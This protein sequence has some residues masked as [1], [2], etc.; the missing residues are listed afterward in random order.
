[1]VLYSD[2]GSYKGNPAP[3]GGGVHG[4]IYD[5]I[6]NKKG[7]GLSKTAITQSGYIPTDNIEK[8]KLTLLTEYDI[9][10][11]DL[12]ESLKDFSIYDENKDTKKPILY[13]VTI[14]EYCNFLKPSNGIGTN[15]QAELLGA[16]T[17]LN[18]FFNSP[19]KYCLLY[20]DSQYVLDTI[21]NK[22][23]IIARDY[24]KKD[25]NEISNKELVIELYQALDKVNSKDKHIYFRWIAGHS[26]FIGNEMS[27]KM[28]TMAAASSNHLQLGYR[29]D[30]ETV[31][32]SSIDTPFKNDKSNHPF[33]SM[34]RFYFNPSRGSSEAK[35][36]LGNLGN[37]EEDTHVG[38]EVSD[39]ALAIVSLRDKDDILEFVKDTQ[40]KW[41]ATMN[42]HDDVLVAGF[43]STISTSTA[44]NDLIRYR[45]YYIDSTGRNRP[46]LFLLDG[47]NKPLTLVMDPPFLS[48][49]TLDQF[50]F[51]ENK[52]NTFIK[53]EYKGKTIDITDHFY[54]NSEK[55][56]ELKK[57][58]NDKI[59]YIDI[60]LSSSD[61]SLKELR[62]TLGIDLPLRNTLK[63]LE[64]Y[65]PKITL[66][67]WSEDSMIAE[68]ATVIELNTGE[69]C[70][71]MASY[72]ANR[73][74]KQ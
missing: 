33:L 48:M 65:F 52:V 72:S 23:D 56:C 27:D 26:G 8:H 45:D 73:F 40:K 24:K 67:I 58:I 37:M 1:M 10:E 68:Y 20:T 32:L 60:P 49:R 4:Y 5:L 11:D 43:L 3:C 18:F 34:D 16:I 28:A 51:L 9:T 66:L 59:K 29:Q 54:S 69:W 35:Y 46:D 17:S 19:I 22:E 21:K 13:Q 53:G 36:Y 15:N 30:N 47:K 31:D 55:K 2:G 41:L 61:I 42:H 39:A 14:K 57:E 74:Q 64:S 63:R 38:K 71:W 44:Y 50:H 7:I 6:P 12:N 70:I 25:N 62:L